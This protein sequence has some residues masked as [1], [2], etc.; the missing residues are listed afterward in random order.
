MLYLK[1]P[2]GFLLGG[3]LYVLMELA[4]RG[5]SH[6]SMFI[7]GGL[8]FL[9]FMAVNRC[10][11]KKAGYLFSAVVCACGITLIEFV[12]GCIFNLWLGL[13]IWDYSYIPLSF[14]G[15]ICEFY[16]TVWIFVSLAGLKLESFISQK[17]DA[18]LEKIRAGKSNY[19]L[20]E[21]K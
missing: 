19:R 2:A 6:Y 4:W 11:V 1:L 14:M 18:A 9:L 10:L 17:A 16:S 7:A 20:H 13:N 12:L 5:Y 8:A 21:D 3:S 15:Q